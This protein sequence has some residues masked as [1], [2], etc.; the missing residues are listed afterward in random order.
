MTYRVVFTMGLNDVVLDE[1]AASPTV[2][3]QVLF[4]HVSKQWKYKCL[5]NAGH[6]YAVAVVH[7]LPVGL[8]RN[9][10]GGS[11]VPALAADK[12]TTG[13]PVNAVAATGSVGVGHRGGSVAPPAAHHLLDP[14]LL[15]GTAREDLRIEVAIVGALAVGSALALC[16]T[17][18]S[19]GSAGGRDEGR[20]REESGEDHVGVEDPDRVSELLVFLS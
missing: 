5:D 11:W 13:R 2:N 4:Q 14:K 15:K 16:K 3:G 6:T 10:T 19:R 18:Q 12:V 7:G 20:G 1:R 9:G 17:T 8:V